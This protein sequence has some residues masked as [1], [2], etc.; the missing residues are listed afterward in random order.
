MVYSLVESNGI[1]TKKNKK[2]K[3]NCLMLGLVD[4]GQIEV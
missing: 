2:K 4:L 1:K 3:I